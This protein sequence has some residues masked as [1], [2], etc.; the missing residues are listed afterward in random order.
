MCRLKRGFTLVELLVVIAIIGILVALLLPAVQAAREA[1]RRTECTNKM[2]QLG[3][4]M[5]NY[6]D[7]WKRLPASNA[8]VEWFGKPRREFN[9]TLRSLPFME[10]T[11]IYDNFDF[12]VPA[13]TRPGNWRD[14]LDDSN[15]IFN[16]KY[17]RMVHPQYLCPS[18]SLAEQVSVEDHFT[19][20]W[21]L[22]QCDYAMNIGDYR[23]VTGVGWGRSGDQNDPDGTGAG[24]GVTE[25]RG[26]SGTND[27]AAR[28]GDIPDGLSNTF[29]LGECIGA[30]SWWQNWGSQ[31]WGNT[32]HPINMRNRYLLDNLPGSAS[33]SDWDWNVGFRSF[34]PGGANF[35]MVDGSVRF[36]SENIDGPTYRAAASRM[37]GESLSLP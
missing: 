10:Q 23:N 16:Y 11:A 3:L 14:L 27:W 17:M 35:C 12:T 26:V 36:L 9:W 4:A 19:N 34:H 1:A 33:T 2:K 13:W 18:D 22:S 24:N 29:L 37:G 8:T 6:H 21:E 7:V 15:A 5:H 32:A 20:S 31:C 30:L 25:V 28:F